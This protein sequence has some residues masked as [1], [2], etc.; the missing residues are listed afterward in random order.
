MDL[1]KLFLLGA[2]GYLLA[3]FFDFAQIRKSRVLSYLF[4]VGFALAALP[5]PI[6]I[7]RFPSPHS[8]PLSRL[9]LALVIISA[10]ATIYVATVEIPLRHKTPGTVYNRGTYKRIR[11]PGF[12]AH[13]IFNIFF[14]L[15]CYT[16]A[17]GAICAFFVLCNLVL[18]AVEDAILFPQLFA[19]YPA[20]KQTTGFILPKIRGH[21]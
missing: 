5:Y 17:I 4:S 3:G 6:L 21:R 16:A 20:Y 15:Y 9:L 8:P 13:L 2:M 7:F 18:V 11:H 1:I 12:L 14:S 10:V 19:D